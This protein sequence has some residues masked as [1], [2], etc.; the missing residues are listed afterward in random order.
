LG[1]FIAEASGH[2]GVNV[3]YDHNFLRFLPVSG[4]KMAFFS[5]NKVMTN[6][7]KN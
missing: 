3:T 6:F 5:K 7:C 1:D 2:P 4:K